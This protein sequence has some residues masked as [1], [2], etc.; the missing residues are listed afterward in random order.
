MNEMHEF[1][2]DLVRMATV[3]Y[4]ADAITIV[5]GH[6]WVKQNPRNNCSITYNPFVNIQ[7]AEE[8]EAWLC[9]RYVILITN[10]SIYLKSHEG[11]L[12]PIYATAQHDGTVDQIRK[13]KVELALHVAHV[14]G[15]FE[16]C[17]LS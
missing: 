13:G 16:R 4:G 7:Q 11:D 14:N 5:P 6:V 2:K 17:M 10:E 3:L 15:V 8:L 12:T 1:H 9:K